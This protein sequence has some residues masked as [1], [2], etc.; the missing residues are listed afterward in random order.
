MFKPHRLN[1]D[2]LHWQRDGRS[3]LNGIDAELRPGEM[4]GIIGPNGAGKSSLL[5]CMSGLEQQYSGAV[6]I[7]SNEIRQIQS[8]SL[9][10]IL[11]FLPQ[12][13]EVQWPLSVKYLVELGRIPHQ[14]FNRH[15][16]DEDNAAVK[17]AMKSAEVMHLRDRPAN[18]LSGG[19]LARVLIARMLASQA[20]IL[21]A[22]EPTAALDPYH[23]WHVMELFKG[24]CQSGGSAVVVL[25]DLNL[26]Q[27]FCDRLIL[28]QHGRVVAV[29]APSEVLRDDLLASVYG[30][31][32]ARSSDGSVISATGRID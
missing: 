29:G 9:S 1:V 28:L 31:C 2:K 6:I 24:H 19:E 18:Q 30:I 13:R 32:V 11:A 15:L 27:R 14:G 16:S 23:Q 4:L 10:K 21:L 12:T 5:R 17:M 26:A 7:D 8:L 25:H 20:G 3:V 22:D